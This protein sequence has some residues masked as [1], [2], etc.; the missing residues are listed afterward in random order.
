MMDEKYPK[1]LRDGY[2]WRVGVC[3]FCGSETR[4]YGEDDPNG[5]G[6][7]W[8]LCTNHDSCNAQGPYRDTSTG[9]LDALAEVAERDRLRKALRRIRR[10]FA[11]HPDAGFQT[12]VETIHEYLRLEGIDPDSLGDGES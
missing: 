12:F 3:G 11:E 8:A 10:H 2:R 5:N 9:A 1:V 6:K 4:A 7:S